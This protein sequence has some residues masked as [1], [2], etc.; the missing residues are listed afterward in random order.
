MLPGPDLLVKCPHCGNDKRLMSLM[1]GN[2]FGALQWSDTYQYAP[3]LPRLS[4]VQKC[5]SCQEYFMLPDEEPRY[6]TDK[7]DSFSCFETGRLSYSEIKEAMAALENSGLSK[8][9]ERSLRFEFLHRF[10]DAFRE[11]DKDS[12]DFTGDIPQDKE[13]SEADWDLHR[14]NLK[15]LIVLLQEEWSV[16]ALVLAEL[17]REAGMFDESLA[18][19]EQYSPSEPFFEKLAKEIEVKSLD[20]DDKVFRLEK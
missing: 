3:M 4:S 7:D 12:R 6:V 1:S 19:L 8:D 14:D 17:Y 20:N 15:K 2:T 13:R 18:L 11:F 16:D 10:N 9:Q 5:P